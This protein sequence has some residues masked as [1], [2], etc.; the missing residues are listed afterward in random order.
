MR[1]KVFLF[2]ICT[3]LFVQGCTQQDVSS[4]DVS[5]SEQEMLSIAA[6][7]L[8]L[9]NDQYV[10]NL[11]GNEAAKLGITEDSY[12]KM[13]DNIA[14]TNA[15]IEN[16]KKDP[17]MQ[18]SLTNPQEIK[19]NNIRLKSGSETSGKATM[20]PSSN[21]TTYLLS[22]PRN[23]TGNVTFTF[24][25]TALTN[26]AS[27][28]VDTKYGIQ[29][30]SFVSCLSSIDTKSVQIPATPSCWEIKGYLHSGNGIITMWYALRSLYV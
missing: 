7:Y 10:L 1:I 14:E 18:I 28:H 16:A 27:L 19:P 25:G 20:T 11:S 29:N 3:I 13:L 26:S 4:D 2:L 17:N 9:D 15:F 5:K 12:I 6:K 24:S 23:G 8:T 22:I 21:G 30:L